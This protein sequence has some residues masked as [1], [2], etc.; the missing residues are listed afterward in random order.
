MNLRSKIPFFLASIKRDETQ[1][2]WLE[3]LQS[4]SSAFIDTG[5]SG[6]N[7]NLSLNMTFYIEKFFEYGGIFGNYTLDENANAFRVICAE[8]ASRIYFNANTRCANAAAKSINSGFFG[9]KH[10]LRLEKT[11]LTVDGVASSIANINGTVKISIFLIIDPLHISI[12]YLPD[13]FTDIFSSFTLIKIA[14]HVFII[15]SIKPPN[16]KVNNRILAH[17]AQYALRFYV[18]YISF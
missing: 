17:F 3:Y 14:S 8:N 6:N 4:D 11:K 7:N 5:V 18:V 1:P 2:I 13:F 9:S 15:T 16:I 10:T 12:S